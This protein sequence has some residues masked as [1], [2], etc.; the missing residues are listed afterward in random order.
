VDT[1][2]RPAFEH[3]RARGVRLAVISNTMRTPGATLRKVLDRFGL[4]DCFAHTT[5]S[6]EVGVRKPDPE[7][8]ALTLRALQVER[9]VAVHVGDDPVLDVLGARDAG[10]RVIQVTSASLRA[11]GARRPDAVVRSLATLPDALAQ[12]DGA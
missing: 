12:L 10:L 5:F 7:I 2:A 11:L 9:A 6:D 4:L 8:F 3:L 1:G